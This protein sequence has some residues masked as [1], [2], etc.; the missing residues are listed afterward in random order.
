MSAIELK[1]F[2][3]QCSQE[4]RLFLQALLHHEQLA[5]DPAHL[6]DMQRRMTDMDDGRK[7]S[8]DTALKLHQTMSEI[9]A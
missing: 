5:C 1:T 2:V 8:W 3:D 4:D 6:A 7:V 9:G